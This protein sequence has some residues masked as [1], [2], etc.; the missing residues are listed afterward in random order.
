VAEELAAGT[1]RQ[2]EITDAEPVRRQIVAIRR[3]GDG[4]PAG[5]VAV[6]LSM[7]AE[8]PYAGPDGRRKKR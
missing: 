7:L 1:L 4:P 3:R 8:M 5:T 6:F 2:V